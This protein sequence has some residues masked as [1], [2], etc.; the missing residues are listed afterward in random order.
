MLSDNTGMSEDAGQLGALFETIHKHIRKTV[1]LGEP[2]RNAYIALQEAFAEGS[3]ENW[4][5]Y[6]AKAVTQQTYEQARKFLE[7]L[8]PTVP[9]PEISLE[10]DGEVAFDWFREPSRVFSVS[11]G[12]KG[13]LTY[14]GVFGKNKT[15]GVEIFQDDL[16]KVI[17]DNLSRLYSQE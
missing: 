10:P 3:V 5:S 6:G 13:E 4:D 7:S 14:A 2:I 11:I 17:M 12:E 1:T 16:P 9:M 8:P 15:H